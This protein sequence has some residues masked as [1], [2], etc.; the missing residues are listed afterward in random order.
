MKIAIDVLSLFDSH[1]TGIQEYTYHLAKALVKHDE[2]EF[3]LV[4]TGS[5]CPRTELD[6]L[7][8][9]YDHVTRVHIGISNKLLKLGFFFRKPYIDKYIGK[10]DVF[11]STKFNNLSFSPHIQHIV[12]FHDLSY[13]RFPW[14]FSWKHRLWHRTVQPKRIAHEA[15]HIIAVSNS[16]KQDLVQLYKVDPENISVTHLGVSDIYR[17]IKEKNELER[18][19]SKFNLPEKFVLFLGTIEPRKNISTLL[20]AFKLVKRD[21]KYEDLNLVISGHLGWLWRPIIEEARNHPNARN[22]YFTGFVHDEDKPALYSMAE[23]FVYPSFF[24][25]FGF[26]PL[27]AMACGTP[28]L[29][30]YHSSFPEVV[31]LSALTVDPHKYGQMADIIM[32]ILDDPKL[33]NDLSKSGIERAGKFSWTSTADNTLNVFTKVQKNG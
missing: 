26:P 6:E 14:H 12:V 20:K 15:R 8:R 33:A 18:V 7:A 5:K 17:P 27:E 11:L 2:H 9:V 31:E 21:S 25:G 13:E 29:T 23:C 3:I 4:S 1:R 19:R 10:I 32:E 22:I 24:E 28:T 30:S 16:T